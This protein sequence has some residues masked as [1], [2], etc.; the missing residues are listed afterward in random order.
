M[1]KLL[2]SL[3]RVLLPLGA[4]L[5]VN[6]ALRAVTARGHKL[7][8]LLQWRIAPRQPGW[9]DH[10][11]NQYC[12]H[13]SRDPS[14]WARGTLGLLGMKPGCRVLDLCC[15]DGFY[16]YHF[17]STMAS[18]IVALDYDPAG[19]RF[20]KRNF[21]ASNLE[22]RCADIRTGLPKETFDN[23]TW[24]AGIDFFGLPDIKVILEGI[25]NRLAPAGLLSGVAPKLRK[26]EVAHSDQRHEFSSAQEL[27]ALLRDF[28]RNVAVLDL[29]GAAEGR[30]ALYFYASDGSV[31][32]DPDAGL[33]VR[34]P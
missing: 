3:I 4:V 16:P 8:Y 28:F 15:G 34:L 14:P 7:Q 6:R 19:I 1:K 24:D 12:W 21:P 9:F 30:D 22:F 13:D 25:K 18:R 31:P 2:K 29:P 20:A 11:I 33:Y 10:F 32:L 5:A 26:G 17:Y 27:G 23:V